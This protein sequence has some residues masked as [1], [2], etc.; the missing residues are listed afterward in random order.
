[1]EKTGTETY[2][3]PNFLPVDLPPADKMPGHHNF[4]D[5]YASG[6]ELPDTDVSAN[7]N[8]TGSSTPGGGR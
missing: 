6:F 4:R 1:M 8:G 2:P 5:R 3:R 7:E